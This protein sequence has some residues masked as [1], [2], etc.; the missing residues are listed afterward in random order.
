MMEYK[1]YIGKVEFDQDAGII[2][3]EVINTRDVITFRGRSTTESTTAFQESVDDRTRRN[4]PDR[5]TAAER[6]QRVAR[7]VSPWWGRAT[8]AKPRMGRQG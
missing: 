1:G 7:G 8:N 3:G 6:R 4:R 5:N 2:H